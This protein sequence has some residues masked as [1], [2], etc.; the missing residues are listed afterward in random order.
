MDPA[1][2]EKSIGGRYTHAG[3]IR[4]TRYSEGE[5]GLPLQPSFRKRHCSRANVNRY[6]SKNTHLREAIEKLRR[7]HTHR[8][9]RVGTGK[10]HVA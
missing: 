4:I 8:N 3:K 5:K 2:G 9:V 10:E 6:D 7:V 1:S